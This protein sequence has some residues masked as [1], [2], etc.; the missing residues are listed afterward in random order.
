MTMA[1]TPK[2]A[3][4]AP[5]GGAPPGA[6]GARGPGGRAGRPKLPSLVPLL[7][8]YKGQMLLLCLLTMAGSGV[9]L[10]VPLVIARAVDAFIAGRLDLGAELVKLVAIA[11]GTFVFGNLQNL[12]QTIASERVARDLRTKLAEKVSQQTYAQI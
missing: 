3:P 7:K 5:G 6:A 11:V 4:Q 12:V 9:G 2:K 8:P 1:E 10:L